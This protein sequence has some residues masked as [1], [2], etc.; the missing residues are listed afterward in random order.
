MLQKDIPGDY[1]LATNESHTVREFIEEACRLLNI[2]LVWE[3]EGLEEK[4]IDPKTRKPIIEVDSLY[5]RPSE[6]NYLRG[7][8]SK[9]KSEFGWEPKVTF[10]ELVKIMM[11]S[12]IKKFGLRNL[13]FL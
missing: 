2:G 5:F 1:V 12:D 3:G 7:D 11:E 8:Y 6:V 4:G 10:K 9:A 13:E